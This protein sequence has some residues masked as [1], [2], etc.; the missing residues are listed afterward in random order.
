MVSTAI[1]HAEREGYNLTTLSYSEPTALAALA[2]IAHGRT[3]E[4][5]PPLQWL[6]DRQSPD[7]SVGISARDSLPAWPTGLAMLA[8]LAWSAAVDQ[9]SSLISR[10]GSPTYAASVAKGVRHLLHS[11]GK[12]LARSADMGHDTSLIGWPW[13]DGTHSWIEPTA[14]NV[15]AL[16]SARHSSRHAPHDETEL[17]SR[18]TFPHAEREGYNLGDHAR[19]REAVRLLID[20]LLPQGGCNY[21]N[22]TVLGQALRPHVQPTGLALLALA[23]ESDAA[24]RIDAAIRYLHGELSAGTAA[25]SLAYGVMGCQAHDAA[26]PQSMDW[27]EAAYHRVNDSSHTAVQ[28]ALLALAASGDDCPLVRLPQK[29]SAIS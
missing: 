3:K 5:E 29:A 11:R 10:A 14:W 7:G 4:A 23:G 12:P 27:L 15:L 22:T 1:P 24:G 8:M 16:K 25:A 2:L 6:I 19:T 28:L 9:A 18:K 13:V 20:R 17:E 21:G 26:P